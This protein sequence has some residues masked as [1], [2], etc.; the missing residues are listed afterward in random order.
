MSEF[1]IDEILRITGGESFNFKRNECFSEF[2]FDTRNIKNE[3]T[4]FFALSSDNGDGHRFIPGL[5][6]FKGAA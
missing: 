5:N 6:S 3:N 4:L 1:K 2:E